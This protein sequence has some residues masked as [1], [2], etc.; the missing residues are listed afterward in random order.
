MTSLLNHTQHHNK[1]I[2]QICTCHKHHCPYCDP[3][4]PFEGDSTYVK[5]YHKHPIDLY[6]IPK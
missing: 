6:K 3:Q 5:D 1:C 4:L 2:C